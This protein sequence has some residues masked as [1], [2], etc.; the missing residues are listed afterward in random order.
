MNNL[1]IIIEEIDLN[2]M[3]I[4]ILEK[5]MEMEINLMESLITV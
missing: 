5:E 2:L 3:E 1:K 4:D